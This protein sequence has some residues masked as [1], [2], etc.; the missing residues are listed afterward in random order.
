MF[1]CQGK[2]QIILELG[3]RPFGVS[4][5][6]IRFLCAPLRLIV[7]C[8]APRGGGMNSWKL[9]NLYLRALTLGEKKFFHCPFSVKVSN[10][11]GIGNAFDPN[12][13]A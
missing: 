13:S 6:C 10:I 1:I 5:F 4:F 2:I 8:L 12:K 7:R 3:R 9:H 11:S